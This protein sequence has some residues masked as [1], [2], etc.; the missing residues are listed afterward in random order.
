M[1]QMIKIYEAKIKGQAIK[2]ELDLFLA[3]QFTQST[4]TILQTGTF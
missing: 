2:V 4:K 1:H 3:F